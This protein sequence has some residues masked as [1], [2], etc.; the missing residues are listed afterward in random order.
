[1]VEFDEYFRV[2]PLKTYH[3]VVLM[4]EFMEELAPKVWPEEK[5]VGEEHFR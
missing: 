2:E 5:R 3:R 1:M 4:R